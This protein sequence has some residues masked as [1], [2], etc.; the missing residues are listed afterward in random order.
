M[1]EKPETELVVR[2]G[3]NPGRL[4]EQSSALV[5]NGISAMIASRFSVPKFL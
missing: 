4:L 1:E 2:A 3:L 5:F